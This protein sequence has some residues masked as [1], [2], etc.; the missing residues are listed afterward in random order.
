MT[1]EVSLRKYHLISFVVW[2]RSLFTLRVKNISDS[3]HSHIFFRKYALSIST[4]ASVF[5]DAINPILTNT[6]IHQKNNFS[7]RQISKYS[8]YFSKN[9][10]HI[11]TAETTRPSIWFYSYEFYVFT[12][13]K[14]QITRSDRSFSY[15][16]SRISFFEFNLFSFEEFERFARYTMRTYRWPF[17]FGQAA[18]SRAF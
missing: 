6:K 12:K 7:F 10:V 2:K 18:L 17:N 3:F 4:R 14:L 16:R 9:S 13:K 11:R 15:C 1:I 8:I 5:S